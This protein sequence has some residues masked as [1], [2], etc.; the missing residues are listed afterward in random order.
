[1]STKQYMRKA[2]LI[3]GNVDEHALDLSELRF[4]FSTRRGDFQTPNSADIRIYNVSDKTADRIRQTLPQPEFTRIVVQGGYDGNFGVLFDGEII[5][6]RHGRESPTDTYLDITAADGDSAYNY[7][8][9]AMSLA[10]GSTP[11]DEVSAILKDMARH[12]VTAGHVPDLPGN[13]LPRG[14]VIYGMSRDAL[15]N[16]AE[17]TQTSWSIQDGKLQMVPETSYIEGEIPVITSATGMIGLPT[18]TQNGINVRVLLNPNIKIGQAIKLDNKSIQGFRFGLGV[19]QQLGNENAEALAKVNNDGLYYVMLAEHS[20]DTRGDAWYSD[21]VCLAIDASVRPSIK[22]S[23]RFPL[24]S[25]YFGAI[26]RRG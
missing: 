13:P 10:A 21:L 23:A 9:T 12:G 26:K 4:Q 5:Q 11:N 7:S 14:K 20:G 15:R 18:Q 17:N 3:V 16:V 19:K 2:S 1:M 25:D 6:V 24:G 22:S 8:V